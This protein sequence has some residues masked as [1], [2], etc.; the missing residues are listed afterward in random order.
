MIV[1]SIYMRKIGTTHNAGW[2]N[3]EIY[4]SINELKEYRDANI[5]AEL[6]DNA[7]IVYHPQFV[8]PIG[9]N[10]LSC[11]KNPRTIHVYNGYE[12]V[13]VPGANLSYE[14]IEYDKLPRDN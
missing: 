10:I 11:S 13:W 5:L 4:E 9:T 8:F 14:S 2:S 6:D 1:C 3:A 7:Y 12:V